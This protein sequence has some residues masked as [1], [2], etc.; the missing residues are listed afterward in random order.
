MF[1]RY[2]T[3]NGIHEFSITK[4][5]KFDDEPWKLEYHAHLFSLLQED[6]DFGDIKIPKFEFK[7]LDKQLIVNSEYIKGRQWQ[8]GDLWDN[9]DLIANN[10]VL[11]EGNYSMND[12]TPWN[13]VTEV[14]TNDIYYVDCEGY[15]KCTISER[16]RILE[17]MQD[18]IIK[19]TYNP[20]LRTH[21]IQSRFKM[22]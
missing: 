21:R 4:I 11:K 2:N 13:F 7:V 6:D 5:F 17:Q 18:K 9:A 15:D 19:R 3:N 14:D 20:G 10:L 1:K 8:D 22:I 16:A 12:Y